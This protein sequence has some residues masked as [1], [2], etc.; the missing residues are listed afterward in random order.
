MA[1]T[2]NT[3]DRTDITEQAANAI[4]DG[5]VTTPP[6]FQSLLGG[7]TGEYPG[8]EYDGMFVP[9]YTG[10]TTDRGDV[11]QMA[12][13]DA[14]SDNVPTGSIPESKDEARGGAVWFYTEWMAREQAARLVKQLPE[15]PRFEFNPRHVAEEIQLP[16]NGLVALGR[17]VFNEKSIPVV[18][19]WTKNPA[20]THQFCHTRANSEALWFDAGEQYPLVGE[21]GVKECDHVLAPDVR[22][23]KVCRIAF[24]EAQ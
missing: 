15:M 14:D 6:K 12:F 20:R 21:S 18:Y 7:D 5:I 10:G 1:Q 11:L 4:R 17:E 13:A 19:V 24:G 8:V 2:D 22:G 16:T 23:Y 3:T 9:D